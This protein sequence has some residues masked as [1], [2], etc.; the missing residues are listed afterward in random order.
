MTCNYCG[1]RNGVGE[2]RCR[3]CGRRPDDILNVNVGALATKL[4]PAPQVELLEA[5]EASPRPL[6][7]TP[8]LARAVQR[9]LFQEKPDS[10]VIPFESYAPP[11]PR[12]KSPA[13]PRAAAKPSLRRSRVSE[14]QGK[15]DFLPALPPAPR[16]LGTTV[17]AVIVCEAPVATPLHRAVAAAIDWALVL[18]AYGIFLLGYFVGGGEFVANR[19]NYMVFGGALAAIAL[20]YGLMYAIA[21]R[22]TLGMNWAHLR[23]TTFDGF[24]PDGKQR[25]YRLLGSSLSLCTVL[26]LAWSLADEESLGWQDHISRTFPTP[27]EVETLTFRRR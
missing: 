25:L 2:H 10:K 23:L 26:G 11:A 8:N 4:Q 15:L 27:R 5:A 12:A 9:P 14:D 24:K 6:S 20:T 1:S 17:D 21:G 7:R 13:P 3:R 22:E 16:K 18:I 19:L